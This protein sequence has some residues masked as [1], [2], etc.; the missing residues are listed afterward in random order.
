MKNIVEIEFERSI[1]IA[2][3][4]IGRKITK[5]FDR[6]RVKVEIFKNI[7]GKIVV[8]IEGKTILLKKFIKKTQGALSEGSHHK[9]KSILGEDSPRL[10]KFF[11]FLKI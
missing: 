1:K 3:N 7:D 2:L 11:Y 9:L 4:I 5:F 10:L 8:K 6:G